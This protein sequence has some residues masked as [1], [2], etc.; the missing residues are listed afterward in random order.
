MIFN[1]LKLAI[2]LLI[3]NPFFTFINVMGL[4]TGFAVFYI[5]TQHASF[6]LKSDQFYKD[7]DRIFRLYFDFYHHTGLDWTHYLCSAFPS[8]ITTIALTVRCK[9]LLQRKTMKTILSIC[10]LTIIVQEGI[11][12]PKKAEL[13]SLNGHSVYY[14]VYGKGE[15]LFLLHGYTLSSRHWQPYVD[16]YDDDYEVYL[17]DLQGHGKSGPYKEDLSIKSV[18]KDIH[19]LI[20]YLELESVYAIGYSYGG[21]VLFHLALMDPG[22]IKS[23]ISIGACGI[24]RSK[25]FPRMLELL[26][27][28]NIQNLKWMY[29]HQTDE[30]Q[31]RIILDQFPNMNSAMSDEDIKQIEAPVFIVL[32]DKDDL[33]PLETVS[34]VRK[35]LPNSFLWIIPN[36][37]HGAHEGKNKDEFVRM[38]TS[39]FK[40]GF[41]TDTQH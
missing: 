18:A 7:H 5:L 23:L 9:D 16:A 11:S 36:T 37:G 39:F 34:R 14:E 27:Y 3:R 28:E 25:N 13:V 22:I 30:E 8:V 33:V 10:I 35:N 20:K 31:I 2:R 15:P 17:V 32:G 21:Q 12:Q 26:S 38:S 4:S 41:F 19:A 29:E 1:Y 6:E 40:D 24:W